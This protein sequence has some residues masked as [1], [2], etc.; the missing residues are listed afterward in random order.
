MQK[1]LNGASRTHTQLTPK[2][3]CS[4]I[5]TFAHRVPAFPYSSPV[6]SLPFF[7]S[8]ALSIN[9]YIMPW[10]PCTKGQGDSWVS[11]PIAEH[12]DVHTSAFHPTPPPI[13]R[14]PLPWAL[15]RSLPSRL[16]LLFKTSLITQKWDAQSSQKTTPLPQAEE[17]FTEAIR[18]TNLQRDKVGKKSQFT[19]PQLICSTSHLLHQETL[20]DSFS[21]LSTCIL[22]RKDDENDS[23][24][25]CMPS[26]YQ[27]MPPSNPVNASS[28]F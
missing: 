6:R 28:L 15:Q 5:P 27:Q 18:A 2:T 23:C 12:R 9:I 19:S 14:F 8:A 10:G 13:P 7:L 1:G 24:A 22:G 16:H 20:Q 4:K 11:K 25:C 21:G 17:H 3:D 26:R